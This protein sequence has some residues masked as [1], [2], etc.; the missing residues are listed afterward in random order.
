M[1]RNRSVYV[2]ATKYLMQSTDCTLSSF[3][4]AKIIYML[5]KASLIRV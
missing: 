5:N 2:L 3:A 4:F 1:S